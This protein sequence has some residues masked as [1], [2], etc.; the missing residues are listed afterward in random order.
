M[1]V[2]SIEPL[3]NTFENN[4]LLYRKE[5]CDYFQRKGLVVQAYKPLQRGG[6]VLESPI[7]KSIAEK[8]QKTPAQVCLRWNLDKGN[9]VVFKSLTPSRIQENVDVFDFSLSED[10]LQKLDALTT[11]EVVQEAQGHWEQRRQGTPAPWGEGLRPRREDEV[12]APSAP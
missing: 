1:K 11:P 12:V 4:P 5:W 7:V 10:D 6:P 9:A 8:A 3:V 2:A